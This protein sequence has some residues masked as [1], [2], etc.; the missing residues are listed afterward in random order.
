M[1]TMRLNRFLARS[2]VASRR[3]AD[4]L[5]VRGEVRVNGEV[6]REHGVQVD[7]EHDV[8]EVGGRRIRL[9]VAG[10][11]WRYYKPRGVICSLR[12]EKGRPDLSA[13]A[14][15]L[16]P[17]AVPAGRLDRDSEGLLLWSDDGAWVARMTHPRYGIAKTYRVTLA[18]GVGADF[19]ERLAGVDRLD[20]GTRLTHAIEILRIDRRTR[21]TVIDLV[22][23]EGK[24]RQVRRM[25]E[26]LGH[27]VI[28]LVRV[29]EGTIRVDGLP[30]GTIE[31]VTGRARE[32]FVQE[33]EA[34]VQRS[35]SSGEMPSGGDALSTSA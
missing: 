13:V 26:S 19:A 6:V 34:A 25:L 4:E 29:A 23:R 27:D 31:E 33:L 15:T 10:R 14:A 7:P 2:G 3:H 17:G 1:T 28:R 11:L 21:K 32:Q 20:D 5:V 24:R 9:P 22:L 8:V 16:P 35:N 12:D 18:G 30:P